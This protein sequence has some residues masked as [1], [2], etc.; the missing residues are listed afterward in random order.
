MTVR[1]P[2]ESHRSLTRAL[3]ARCGLPRPAA[4]AAA[5]A[6]AY[7]DQRGLTSHGLNAVVT[8]YAPRLLDGRINRNARPRRVRQQGA[9]T[10]LDGDNGLGLVT[11]TSA[12]DLAAEAARRHGLAA[13]AVRHSSHFGAAGYYTHRLATA[14]LIGLAMSNCG[15]QGIVPPLGGAV[16]LLGTNPLSVAVPAAGLPPFVLDMS[17]TVVAAGRVRA[18]LRDGQRVPPGWLVGR[19]GR[20]VSD[21]AAYQA[22]RADLAWLGGRLATGAAK[23]YGLGLLVDLMC[24][25]LA[26]AACGPQPEALQATAPAEDH[27]VGH[28]ALALE[29]AVF[30]DPDQ[31][32]ADAADLLNTVTA[33]PPASYADGVTYPGAPEAERAASAR[34]AGV[35]LPY[36]VA[37]AV[38]QLAEELDVPLP[39]ALQAEVV[40]P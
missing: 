8:L 21:P 36:T 22:G 35:P 25:P 14:G 1:L 6:I 11:M 10:V 23:G 20:G 27:D 13:V 33:C 2:L 19:D 17:T 29:P 15:A 9:V 39:A 26:G 40:R 18:A 38:R 37:I 28:I 5:E 3:L 24:G 7:A 31:I 4:H 34:A 12:V 16:R 30:G 32:M